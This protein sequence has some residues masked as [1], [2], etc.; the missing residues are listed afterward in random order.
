MTHK[1]TKKEH[2]DM[3][4]FL[5]AIPDFEERGV[6]RIFKCPFCKKGCNCIQVRI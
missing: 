4:E 3:I 6:E 5:M 2:H 1:L